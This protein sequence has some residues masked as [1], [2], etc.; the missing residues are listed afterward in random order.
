MRRILF[1]LSFLVVLSFGVFAQTQSQE[2]SEDDGV[3]VIIKNLPEWETVR[4]QAVLI[5]SQ[6]DLRKNLGDRPV[7]DLI[8]FAGGTEAAT[9]QYEAGKLLIV[10]FNTPQFSIDADEKVKQRLAEL[11]GNP[12]IF[13][14]RIGNYNAFVFDGSDEAAANALL[15][16]IDYGKIVQWL[17][18]DPFLYERAERN[19]AR[20]LSELFISTVVAI[21]SG[22]GISVLLGIGAGAVFF[23]IRKRQRDSI[24]KFS[25]A[26]GMLRLNLD[27]LT[28]EVAPDRLLKD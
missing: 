10:E 27:E 2:I 18:E 1:V 24:D 11:G 8:N 23:Y 6:D 15:D 22:L 25:D 21:V 26:G 19:Y 14:R 16:Q 20:S 9:A 5:K 12:P 17:G 7:F 28:P 13:Y 3:P 4:G